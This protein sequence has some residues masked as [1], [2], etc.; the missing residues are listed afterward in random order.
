[1]KNSHKKPCAGI[2]RLARLCIQH[3]QFTDCFADAH[4]HSGYGHRGHTK[5]FGQRA[6]FPRQQAQEA[7]KQQAQQFSRHLATQFEQLSARKQQLNAQ[8]AELNKIY[9]DALNKP[10]ALTRM[11]TGIKDFCSISPKQANKRNPKP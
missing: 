2:Q 1:M 5:G 10:Y 3:L 11:W 9:Q 6:D 7:N 8:V 4:G